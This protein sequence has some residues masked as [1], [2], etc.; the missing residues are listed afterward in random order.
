MRILAFDL[1]STIGYCVG[2]PEKLPLTGTVQLPASGPEIGP[3][4]DFWDQWLDLLLGRHSPEQIC[5]EAPFI[6]TS[7]A[8]ITTVRKLS[9]LGSHLELICYRRK[10]PVREVSNIS[11]KKAVGS[12]KF[13]KDDVMAAARR[14][15]LDPSNYDESDA[16]AVWIA[17][18]KD[19]APASAPF[20]DGKLAG[21]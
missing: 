21:L 13:K 8:N 14:C 3:F 1:A 6:D 17:T 18:V 7:K 2:E 12:G 16:W 9:S 4:L 20:W 19:M 15:G 5:Y 11:A 10:L